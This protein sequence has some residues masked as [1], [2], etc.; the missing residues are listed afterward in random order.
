MVILWLGCVAAANPADSS[1]KKN[2]VGNLGSILVMNGRKY[3]GDRTSHPNTIP[4]ITSEIEKSYALP[5]CLSR[6][7]HQTAIE[8]RIEQDY[9]ID[10]I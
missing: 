10:G 2:L 3:T 4:P 8:N 5:H 7:I 9:T 6:L 1:V